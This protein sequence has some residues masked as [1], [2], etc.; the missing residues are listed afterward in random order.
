MPIFQGRTLGIAVTTAALL[1]GLLAPLPAP[2][3]PPSGA[4][5]PLPQLT[6]SEAVHYA[7][8]NNPALAVQRQQHGIA[9]AGI[10]I[11]HTY[12]FNPTWEG[13]VRAAEGPE[14]AG[15]TNRV[16]NEHKVFIDVE[17]R[18]QMGYRI[19][20]AQATLSR[21]DCEIAFQEVSVAVQAA[22]AFDTV[23]YRRE[24]LQLAERT[25]QL[26]ERSADQIAKLV[27]GGRLRGVD[28]LLAR[29]EVN[30]FRAQLGPAQTSLETAEA[31]LR[32][33]LGVVEGNVA[34]NG[35]LESPPSP[36]PPDVLE[37]AA[38]ERRPDVKARQA[39][40][41]EAEAR[42]RLEIANRYGNPNV[43]P[44]YEY[45]PT[46]INL[47]GVQITMPLPVFNTHKGEIQQ[48]EAE[49]DRTVLELRQTE[50]QVTQ[51]VRAALARLEAARRWVDTYQSVVLKDL[52]SA[53]TDIEKLFSQGD[54][55]TDVLRVI[56]VRR[57]LLRAQDGYLDALYEARQAQDDLAAALGDP[58]VVC[59]PAHPAL[60]LEPLQTPKKP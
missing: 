23:L 4:P 21:T 29:T 10:V 12:P 22:R 3:D 45:D 8:L 31:D 28:L 1:G 52:R 47:I 59:P 53:E 13:K 30:D 41:G 43:G 34:V 14:S 11:A 55:G 36:P 44:A 26:N 16:S 37:K 57:K 18:G 56:D 33:V 54:P 42:L 32:R 24:K 25:V 19:D 46:R 9:A 2:A 38:H 35:Y 58:S 5:A 51:D 49:R 7:L 40:I 27:E 60:L 20:G 15:I 6:L 39:A 48:R 50:M 17:L